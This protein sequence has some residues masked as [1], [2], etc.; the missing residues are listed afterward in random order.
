MAL[1]LQAA[2]P[3]LCQPFIY[4]TKKVAIFWLRSTNTDIDKLVIY[5]IKYI[6]YC[7]ALT[8]MHYQ[9]DLCDFKLTFMYWKMSQI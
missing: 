8:W 6:N 4:E 9:D 5:H 2:L 7:T 1:L 3:W